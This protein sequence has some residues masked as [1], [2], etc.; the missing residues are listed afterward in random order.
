MISFTLSSLSGMAIAHVLYLLWL[1][2]SFEY[3][4]LFLIFFFTFYFFLSL[5]FCLLYSFESFRWG[6]PEHRDSFPSLRISTFPVSSLLIRLSDHVSCLVWHFFFLISSIS[7]WYFLR[8]SISLL[9]LPICFCILST[10]STRALSI[11]IIIVLNYQFYNS[12]AP[13]IFNSSS[14]IWSISSSW[15]RVFICLWGCLVIFSC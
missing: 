7:F 2:Y 6:T 4:L 9:T 3:S 5:F 8:I 15:V 13:A 1:C 10:L 14:D 11:I 12:N